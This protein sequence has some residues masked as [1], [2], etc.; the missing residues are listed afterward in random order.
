MCGL[1]RRRFWKGEYE[2]DKICAYQT[3]YECL[4]AISR[5]IAPIAPFFADWFFTNLNAVTKQLSVDSVHH[6]D[7]PKADDHHIDKELEERM[8]LAQDI[9][10]LI[11]SLRKKVN[12]PDGQIGIKVRQPLQKV[13]IPAIDDSFAKKIKMVE[14][15][16]KSETN[17]KE[18]ELLPA[19]N[20]FIKKK[21]KPILKHW[22]KTGLKNEMGCRKNSETWRMLK[23]IKSR[24][25]I[26]Y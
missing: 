18:I 16:I 23:L 20:N 10:S 2:H 24:K 15:I 12:L 9:S 13:I 1:C 22:E 25:E 5:L 6:S 21:E 19:N 17:I 14:E 4:E 26:I 8:Q 3:L 11:L 7:F